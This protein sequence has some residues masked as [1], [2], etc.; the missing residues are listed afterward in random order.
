MDKEFSPM[1]N[2]QSELKRAEKEQNQQTNPKSEA[3]FS[4]T[5]IDAFAPPS[6][7]VKPE[8]TVVQDNLPPEE[9]IVEEKSAT[10]QASAMTDN[11]L[12]DCEGKIV[13]GI[14]VKGLRLIDENEVLRVVSTKN[15]TEF[16]AYE[17][18]KD[19]QAI[20]NIGYFSD[21]IP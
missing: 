6:K 14:T 3:D 17:V 18:Q 19:L 5:N 8:K 12:P 2:L 16:H 13:Q 11:N 20:Y 7:Y 9:T 4:F 10:Y 21:I 15:G 1:R